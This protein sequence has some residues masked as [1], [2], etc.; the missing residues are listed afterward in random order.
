MDM[1]LKQPKKHTAM[2]YK[3]NGQ[4]L[5]L[6]AKNYLSGLISQINWSL[7][8]DRFSDNNFNLYFFEKIFK[9]AFLLL[10][11]TNFVYAEGTKTVS[12]NGAGTLST[13]VINPGSPSGSFLNCGEDSRIYF[14][15]KN[16]S[17]ESL[18]F[19]FR[20]NTGGPGSARATDMYY[21]IYNPSGV[22]VVS[23]KWDPTVAVAGSIDTYAQAV[24]GPNIGATTAGYIPLVFTPTS[25]AGA[26]W[27]EFYRSSDLGVTMNATQAQAEYFDFSVADNSGLFTVRNGRVHSD[28][29]AFSSATIISSAEPVLYAYTADQVV[30]KIDF[31]VGFKPIGYIVAVNSYGVSTS[32]T[33]DVTRRSI[34]SAVTPPLTNGY[35]IFLNIPDSSIYPPG[36]TPADPTF[37]SPAIT[38][39]GPYLVHFN[40]SEPGDAKI[41]FNLNGVAGYQQNT[42]DRILEVFN[43]PAGDNTATWDGKD[44][45]GV[46]VPDGTVMNLQASFLKGRYNLPIGDAEINTGG[47]RISTISPVTVASTQMFWDDSKLTTVG[48]AC[49][50]TTDNNS[51]QTGAGL[52]NTYTGTASPA[53]AWNGDGNSAQVI[54]APT[55]GGGDSNSNPCDDYGNLRIM[56]TYGWGMVYTSSNLVINKANCASSTD[57]QCFSPVVGC[58]TTDLS[59]Y[60]LNSNSNAATLEYDNFVSSFH[61]TAIRTNDGSFQIW[62]QGVANDGTADVLSPLTINSNNYP[63]LTGTVLKVALGSNSKYYP[64]GSIVSTVPTVNAQ[65]IILTTTGLFAVGKEDGVIDNA[66]TTSNTLQKLSIATSGGTLGAQ[67]DGLPEGIDAGDVKMLFASEG[68]VALTTC[69]GNVF[70]LANLGLTGSGRDYSALRGTGSTN[71]GNA[72]QWYKVTTSET[73][74]PVLSNVVACRGNGTS[75]IALK[76]DGTLWTWGSI[77]YLGNNTAAAI[78]TRA[79]QMTLPAGATIKMFG[80]TSRFITR[81][82][83]TNTLANSY[84][85]LDTTGNL[86]SLGDNGFRTL[87]DWTTNERTSW[88]QARYTS[89]SGAFMNDI[90]WISPN[91]HDVQYCGINVINSAGELYAWG[92]DNSSMLGTSAATGPTRPAGI[93]ATSIIMA[94]ETGGH[95]SLVI[96]KC[97]T[98]FGY[99]GH[100]VGGSMG[101]GSSADA[102]QTTYTFATS[103]VKVCGVETGT[104]AGTSA[105]NTNGIYCTTEK[106]Q[107]FGTPT[108]GTFSIVS[109]SATITGNILSFTGAGTVVA[110]YTMPLSECGTIVTKDLTLLS[111]VCLD[112]DGDG[113]PNS[114]D[115]DDDNDGILDAT[116]CNSSERVSS[117]NF[118]VATGGSVSSVAG[119]TNVGI[120]STT[121][122][123]RGPTGLQFNTNYTNQSLA[124]NLTG[125]FPTAS[126]TGPI[127][128]FV[129]LRGTD[130]LNGLGNS[131][132][133]EGL[134]VTV[135][136]AGVSY[137]TLSTITGTSTNLTVTPLN[138]AS[139]VG[140]TPTVLIG[141]YKNISLQL[142]IGVATSG[143]LLFA[144]DITSST[145]IEGAANQRDDGDDL[146]IAS[147]SLNSCKDTDGDGIVDFLDLDSDNDGCLDALEGGDALP[148]S[149]LVTAGGT[150]TVGTGSTASNQNLCATAYIGTAADC[151]G[152]TGVP[153]SVNQTSGQTVGNST[154]S[155]IKTACSFCYKAATTGASTALPTYHGITSLSRAGNDGDGSTAN[156][157]PMVRTGAWSVLEAKSKGFVVNRVANPSTDIANPIIGMMVYDTTVNCLKINTDGTAA[158]W[159]CFSTQGCPT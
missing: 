9:T 130:G 139:I 98:K 125:V 132:S 66:L 73:G 109:G 49:T 23:A 7:K 51:N 133:S 4:I 96:Q 80:A 92:Q 18:Y 89:A 70:V 34:T 62:G 108:G 152:S 135:S 106:P 148:G 3:K 119:W 50:A 158:G 27:I 99:V 8:K 88:V 120:N 22:V 29:W 26:Y 31:E 57:A 124:Q 138:G 15:I 84:F 47:F 16:G 102:A 112:T 91:E 6:I 150:V 81:T 149:Y 12:P 71:A 74:N 105:N 1:F 56:N 17:T 72:Q 58:S 103:D 2:R 156:D 64:S 21:K 63:A 75:L 115:L 44:G 14:D 111:E 32:G 123:Y 142:P 93:A 52:N 28:K 129:G 118:V 127:I 153:L 36:T 69:D 13:L 45:L 79:T 20:W 101:D 38:G 83:N 159:K 76:G 145:D 33:F 128:D 107:L 94:A 40:I 48:V 43:L 131:T 59:N 41:T 30:I 39:C 104:F 154:N 151:V 155:L 141:A 53:H 140:G 95:T 68:V 42:T 54:P 19:G 136:Y 134:T 117:G 113:V 55:S 114:I 85:L 110:R 116:E 35:K 143:Q 122:I 11:V 25:G 10:F 146:E 100:R 90:K 46:S 82:F 78:R 5:K 126:G 61:Q 77:T 121:T 144:Y 147:I 86:Y 137:L 37:L 65:A 60:G 87:G 24:A 67:A 157:W 97:Q